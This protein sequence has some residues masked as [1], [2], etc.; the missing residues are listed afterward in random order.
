MLVVVV[1]LVAVVEAGKQL[2]VLLSLFQ[3]GGPESAVGLASYLGAC[4]VVVRRPLRP[5]G[6]RAGVLLR[7]EPLGQGW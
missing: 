1:E 5:P 4:R 2:V 7:S 6:S 3:N